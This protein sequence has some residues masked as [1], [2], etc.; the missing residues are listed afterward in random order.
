MPIERKKVEV[1]LERE[2]HGDD[3]YDV[4]YIDNKEI[5]S[6]HLTNIDELKLVH[7]NETMLK[8][9]TDYLKEE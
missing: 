5:V 6:F 8:F 3:T 2:A 7:A 4:L 1:K 9:I